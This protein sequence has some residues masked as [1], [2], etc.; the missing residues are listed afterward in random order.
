MNTNSGHRCERKRETYPGAAQLVK[1]PVLG[2]MQTFE[3]L[4]RTALHTRTIGRF[5]LV[6]FQ[7]H[8]NVRG[9]TYRHGCSPMR[10]SKRIEGT[11]RIANR[12]LGNK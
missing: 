2:G 3:V 8:R 4:F 11:G 7:L 1:H 10:E 9:S 5:S 12:D 6:R